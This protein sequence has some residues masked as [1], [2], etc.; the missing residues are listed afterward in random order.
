MVYIYDHLDKAQQYNVADKNPIVVGAAI[1]FLK[2]LSVIYSPVA[3]TNSCQISFILC[4]NIRLKLYI[5][6][7]NFHK[8][9]DHIFL[10][11]NN[12]FC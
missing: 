4:Y 6:N 11:E 3:Y 7:K 9:V 12:Y 1:G 10:S 2:I 8:Y 5:K